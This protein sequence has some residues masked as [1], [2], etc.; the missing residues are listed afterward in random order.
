MKVYVVLEY[1]NVKDARAFVD[2]CVRW[3]TW[4]PPNWA[5]KIKPVGMYKVNEA[6]SADPVEVDAEVPLAV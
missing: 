3:L 1:D 6:V 2:A 4:G 5:A